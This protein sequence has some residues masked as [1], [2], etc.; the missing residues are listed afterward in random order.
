[1]SQ[2]EDENRLRELLNSQHEFPC[3]YSFKVICRNAPGVQESIIAG[4]RERTGLALVL[5]ENGMKASRKGNYVSNQKTLVLLKSTVV[6]QEELE[7]SD[8]QLGLTL[9]DAR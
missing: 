3:D 1:M 9:T 8:A 5:G 2:V 7:P 6:L 4:L